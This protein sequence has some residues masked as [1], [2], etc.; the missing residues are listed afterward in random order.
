MIGGLVGVVLSCLCVRN[1]NFVLASC[2]GVEVEADST[3]LGRVM[4]GP[5]AHARGSV[6]CDIKGGALG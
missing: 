6:L 5:L 2:G 3:A 4:S 1:E